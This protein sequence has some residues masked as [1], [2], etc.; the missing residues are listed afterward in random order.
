M[1]GHSLCAL[2]SYVGSTLACIAL[3]SQQLPD[4]SVTCFAC[5]VGAM[6]VLSRQLVQCKK[7]QDTQRKRIARDKSRHHK[8]LEDALA[9]Y[10]VTDNDM[11][12]PS[13]YM[14][15]YGKLQQ[16]NLQ[17][18]LEE[19]F[20]TKPMEQLI[21][22]REEEGKLVGNVSV[23][24]QKFFKEWKLAT[25]IRYVNDSAATAPDYTSISTHLGWSTQKT[26]ADP[27]PVCSQT[28]GRRKWMQRW[29]I[30]WNGKIARVP[31]QA[32]G[33]AA[34]LSEK[35]APQISKR[36]KRYTKNWFPKRDPF[37]VLIWVSP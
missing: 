1:V 3:S 27:G 16:P 29:R 31:T 34:K 17:K 11:A 4:D 19:L 21:L 12:A 6:E 26:G 10:V 20:L 36:K 30:R 14:N 9:M 24:A 8:L 33:S 22:L 28:P 37:L 5:R 25:W 18:T 2:S 23:Q 15:R 32:G 35:A 13:E 7:N